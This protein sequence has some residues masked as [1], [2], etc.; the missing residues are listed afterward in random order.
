MKLC[1]Y[2]VVIF[3]TVLWYFQISA[4]LEEAHK[5]FKSKF[6]R[7]QTE[8]IK[9]RGIDTS[10]EQLCNGENFKK[11]SREICLS[12]RQKSKVSL[13]FI[14]FSISFELNFRDERNNY[15]LWMNINYS[16]KWQKMEFQCNKYN[17]CLNYLSIIVACSHPV[18]LN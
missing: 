8:L 2:C 17:V 12:S 6:D 18:T 9:T 5:W 7:L 11:T 13:T 15:N 16:L 14:S 10:K 1:P 3:D 4:N